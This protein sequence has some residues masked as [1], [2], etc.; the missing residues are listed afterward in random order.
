MSPRFEKTESYFG[1][2]D[3]CIALAMSSLKVSSESTEGRTR[4]CCILMD[5]KAFKF[6]EVFGWAFLM[7]KKASC[8]SLHEFRQQSIFSAR[9]RWH[10]R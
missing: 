7:G 10:S 8:R 2:G 3:A 9:Q 4:D 5:W 6:A 1:R